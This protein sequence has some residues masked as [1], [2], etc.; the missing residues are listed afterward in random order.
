[1]GGAVARALC[2]E[3]EVFSL[4]RRRADLPETVRQLIVP[5][6]QE[7]MAVSAQIPRGAVFVH[8]AAAI[9]AD[10]D[11]LWAANVLGTRA[12]CRLAASR[13]ARRFVMI[14]T[15]GVYG[16]AHGVLRGEDDPVAP[17]GPYAQSKYVSERT[18]QWLHQSDGIPADILRLYSPFALN[19]K[20][21]LLPTVRNK[22][23]AG[24]PLTI[25]SRGA[26]AI[27]PVHVDDVAAAIRLAAWGSR[28]GCDIYNVCGDAAW[29]FEQ[30]V[31]AYSA[32]M[33][34]E[35]AKTYAQQDPGDLLARY[36]K[37]KSAF[38][39]MP[40]H[41]LNDFIKQHAAVDR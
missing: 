11:M 36:Q 25:N 4:S 10:D 28:P 18:V 14:S 15:G 38:D 26:P 35:A 17:L 7:A 8:C 34:R 12:M 39:W 41:G 3:C 2:G 21:G 22:V 29:T 40:Q 1:V 27:Q 6:L 13:E 16:Y 30:I 20:K 31:D 32:A 37:Y 5:D 33:G 23:A 19:Q 24:D 9:F